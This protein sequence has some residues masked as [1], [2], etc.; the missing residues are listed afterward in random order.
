MKTTNYPEFVGAT[1]TPLRV[2]FPFT[3]RTPDVL[4]LFLYPLR[5]TYGT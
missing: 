2:L 4:S 1:I 3:V 5:N